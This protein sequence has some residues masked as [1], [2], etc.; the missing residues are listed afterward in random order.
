MFRQLDRAVRI[1][2]IGIIE[3]QAIPEILSDPTV[4]LELRN[5]VSRR[6]ACLSS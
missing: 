2:S 5:V 3:N 4:G 1:E 6:Q